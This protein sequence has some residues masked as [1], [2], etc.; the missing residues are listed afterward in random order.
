M[1]YGIDNTNQ[2]I[3]KMLLNRH[4]YGGVNSFIVDM[5]GIKNFINAS[6]L[7]FKDLYIRAI[8]KKIG[9]LQ[10]NYYLRVGVAGAPNTGTHPGGEVIEEQLVYGKNGGGISNSFSGYLLNE[11]GYSKGIQ[12]CRDGKML[13]N[14]MVYSHTAFL[15][16]SK[17]S[18]TIYHKVKVNGNLEFMEYVKSFAENIAFEAFAVQAFIEETEED[19]ISIKGRVLKRRPQKAFEYLYEATE[20]GNEKE[21]KLNPGQQVMIVGTYFKRKDVD[22]YDFTNGREYERKGH[23]HVHILNDCTEMQHEVF[24]LR[25]LRV[26]KNTTI[27]L[28]ITPIEHIV[29][30]TPLTE[31]IGEYKCSVTGKSV[32]TLIEEFM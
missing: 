8:L 25:E 32:E 2:S 22:W 4:S 1:N 27:H 7:D 15:E 12:L 11:E 24:H 30:I 3:E 29:K 5:Q 14:R 31:S 6:F 16:E 21:F 10:D 26:L 20:I 13:E 23:Y 9:V 17:N 18:R 28:L 19:A